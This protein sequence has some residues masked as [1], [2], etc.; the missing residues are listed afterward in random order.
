MRVLLVE[1]SPRFRRSI[2][3][4]LTHSGYAV[5]STGD[6]AEGLWFATEHDY[7]AI[8]LDLMLPGLDGLTL[9]QKLRRTGRRAHV[10]ILTARASIEDRVRGLQLGADDYLVKPFAL[11]ELLARVQ[12]L[13]RRRYGEKNPRIQL[14]EMELDTSA[15]RVTRHGRP[16]ELTSLEYLLLDYLAHRRGE[17]VSRPEIEA[18]LYREEADL[19]SNVIDVTIYKLRKKLGGAA[20][21]ETRR[22]LGYILQGAS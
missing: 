14:G 10:L 2:T 19:A 15:R 20:R 9:L 6:G 17:V 4:A 11:E 16:V 13:C 22:G 1:D 5:D 21:I 7:D 18:H 12:A 8:I 3:E